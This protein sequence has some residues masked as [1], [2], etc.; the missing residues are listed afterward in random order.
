MKDSII[1]HHP[2]DWVEAESAVIRDHVSNSLTKPFILIKHLKLGRPTFAGIWLKPSW[3]MSVWY[4]NLVDIFIM[5]LW[6][7]KRQLLMFVSDF[8]PLYVL[9]GARSFTLCFMQ[10]RL[11]AILRFRMLWRRE[12]S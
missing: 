4:L 6:F 12:P 9:Q 11:F 7:N 2:G 8:F 5:R 1:I 3:T 10:L